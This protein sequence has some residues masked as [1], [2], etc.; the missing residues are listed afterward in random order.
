MTSPAPV[1]LHVHSV[2]TLLGATATVD[3]LAARAAADGMRH[4]ALTDSHALYGVIAFDRACRAHGVT[5]LVGMTVNVQP[6]DG[7]DSL[8]AATPGQ[9]V[10]L[11]ADADGYRSLSRLS[12]HLQGGPDR[13]ERI[14]RGV[15]WT[16]LKACAAGVICLGGGRRGWVTRALR[17]GDRAAVHGDDHDRRAA[18][19]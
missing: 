18:P 4:L 10:L 7:V 8:G 16:T 11:A 9:L 3:A 13:H 17:A 5:P 2:Y 6:L 1:H 19:R 12:S 15:D 14:A